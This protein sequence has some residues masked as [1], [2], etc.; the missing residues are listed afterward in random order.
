[1]SACTACD[2]SHWGG[3]YVPQRARPT[4]Y[5]L[6]SESNVRFQKSVVQP[7]LPLLYNYYLLLKILQLVFQVVVLLLVHQDYLVNNRKINI[8]FPESFIYKLML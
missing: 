6:Y 1:M 4:Y 8:I 5:I 3:I 7:S 2:K